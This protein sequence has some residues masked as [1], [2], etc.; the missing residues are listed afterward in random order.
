M[1]DTIM[2]DRDVM[3]RLPS[4]DEVS[5]PEGQRDAA[6]GY[7]TD[8]IKPWDELGFGVWAVCIRDIEL[9]TKTESLA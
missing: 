9:G 3:Y 6:S 1:V 8:F 5:T 4:S 2:S 7:I